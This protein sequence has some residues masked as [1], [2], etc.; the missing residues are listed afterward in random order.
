[1]SRKMIKIKMP[2]EQLTTV[3]VFTNDMLR[4]LESDM[5]SLEPPEQLVLKRTRHAF[6]KMITQYEDQKDDD[7]RTS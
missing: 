4:M 2:Q 1:M 5:D 3:M 6:N 7:N